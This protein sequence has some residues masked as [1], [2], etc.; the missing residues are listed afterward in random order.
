MSAK[1]PQAGDWLLAPPITAVGLRMSDEEIKRH[2]ND[3]IW[4]AMRRADVPSMKEPLR[5]LRDDGKRPDGVTMIPW[6]RR[7]RLAWY[8]T[9]SDTFT[10]THLPVTSLTP[11]ASADK[12]AG[13]KP[14]KYHLLEQTH[15][16]TPVAIETTGAFNAE[17]LQLL[18]EIGRK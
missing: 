9:V 18:Q 6:A 12:A 5:L 8:V 7:R 13:K 11:S 16:F 10:A 4:K 1:Q 2:I 14:S 17:A 3:I 15:I